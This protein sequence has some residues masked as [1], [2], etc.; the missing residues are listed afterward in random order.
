MTSRFAAHAVVA[1][2][3]SLLCRI[4]DTGVRY[5]EQLPSAKLVSESQ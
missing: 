2:S 4:L 1:D 5:S 3:R